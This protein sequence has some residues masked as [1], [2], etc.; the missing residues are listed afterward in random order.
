MNSPTIDFSKYEEKPAASQIDFSKYSSAAPTQPPGA[1]SRIADSI[2]KGVTLDF[3]GGD[4]NVQEAGEV[5]KDLGRGAVANAANISTPGMA[6][7][8]LADKEPKV[9]AFFQQHFPEWLQP[10]PSKD[11]PGDVV[12]NAAPLMLGAEG[13][14]KNSV[15]PVPKPVAAAAAAAPAEGFANSLAYRIARR[16][17][18]IGKAIRMGELASDIADAIKSPAEAPKPPVAAP[19]AAPAPT[20]PPA[21]PPGQV[22]PPEMWGKTIPQPPAAPA[23]AAPSTTAAPEA[24]SDKLRPADSSSIP[25][26]LSGEGVLNQVLTSLDNKTL[27]RVAKSRGINVTQEAQLKPGAADSKLISKIIDDFSPDELDNVRALGLDNSRFKPRGFDYATPEVAREAWHVKVLQTY[28]PD[29]NIPM[30]TMKRIFKG[31]VRP[32]EAA[33]A[34]P[35]VA[36]ASITKPSVP[37]EEE[38]LTDLLKQSIKAAKAKRAAG[39]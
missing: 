3:K 7:R 28:F 12:V 27:L 6:A 36:A 17:P 35:D 33:A 34:A 14:P 23:A 13:L 9:R 21:I 37:I 18:Y 19:P 32:A 8:F 24:I 10:A 39:Q 31:T 25:R 4:P 5:A 1:L 20:G 22:G 11:I 15:E 29:V 16:L 26:T 30:A 38:D 2:K